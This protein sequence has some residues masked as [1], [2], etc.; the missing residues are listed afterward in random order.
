MLQLF[1]HRRPQCCTGSHMFLREVMA[2]AE[3]TKR[4]G[5]MPETAMQLQRVIMKRHFAQWDKLPAN[6]KLKY[7][8]KAAAE[9]VVGQR[10]WRESVATEIGQLSMMASRREESK[11]QGLRPPLLLSSG[12][13]NLA[14]RGRTKAM[15]SEPG[16]TQKHV[17]LLREQARVAPAIP[18]PGV[19]KVPQSFIVDERAA[20]TK[21][22]WLPTV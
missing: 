11:D 22:E 1:L 10:S 19:T 5:A 8:S 4:L 7:E 13:L 14:D 15:V 6:K 9:K 18:S 2:L 3:E 17:R 16:F 12:G 20:R 21:P